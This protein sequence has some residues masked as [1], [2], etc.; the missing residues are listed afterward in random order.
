MINN[1]ANQAEVLNYGGIIGYSIFVRI[2][3]ISDSF[4]LNSQITSILSL[5]LT[6]NIAIV[7]LAFIFELIANPIL[8]G[9]LFGGMFGDLG[10]DIDGNT[11]RKIRSSEAT[12]VCVCGFFRLHCT[13]RP[14]SPLRNLAR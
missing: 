10:S 5:Y 11:R 14:C 3:V 9:V 1:P 8:G 2:D 4:P 6:L 13:P 12:D 7:G